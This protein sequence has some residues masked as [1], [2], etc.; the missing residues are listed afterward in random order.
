MPIIMD[1]FVQSRRNPLIVSS[2]L[3]CR[4]YRKK[5]IKKFQ[6]PQLGLALTSLQLMKYKV[7]STGVLMVTFLTNEN[8]LQ[9]KVARNHPSIHPHST[10]P[11][12]ISQ[13]IVLFLL[14]QHI[15]LGFGTGQILRSTPKWSPTVFDLNMS[16]SSFCNIQAQQTQ[17]GE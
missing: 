13:Q 5:L 10:M 8:I 15:V 7:T 2:S 4:Y 12:P 1:G 17:N 16:S 11:F 14:E 6:F 3:V 9:S